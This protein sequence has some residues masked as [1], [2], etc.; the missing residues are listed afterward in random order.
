MQKDGTDDPIHRA[1]VD[2]D[3]NRLANT[4]GEGVGGT[5]GE[6]SIETSITICKIDSKWD[7]AV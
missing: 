3:M 5:N 4:V 1:A 7:Y 2:R 6:S